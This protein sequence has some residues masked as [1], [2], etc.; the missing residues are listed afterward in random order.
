MPQPINTT[1]NDRAIDPYGAYTRIDPKERSRMHQQFALYTA[2]LVQRAILALG[3]L[4][5]RR[6]LDVGPGYGALMVNLDLQHD[7]V[8]AELRQLDL[9]AELLGHAQRCAQARGV[10]SVNH[11]G[12]IDAAP[13]PDHLL[14]NDLVVC[15]FTATHFRNLPRAMVHM[16]QALLPAGLLVLVDVDYC[17]SLSAGCPALAQTLAEVQGRLHTTDLSAAL[18]RAAMQAG[19]VPAEGMPCGDW[20]Q[21]LAGAEAVQQRGLRFV[22]HFHAEDPAL[23]AWRRI[24]PDAL[25]MLRRMAHI[26]TR[27]S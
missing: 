14:G 7:S 17:A 1:A 26:Y 22:S 11:V 24:G 21:T 20:L 2:P 10:V 6:V 8:P 19:L 5:G 9:N 15:S 16:H 3:G 25:L 13:L 18:P 4:D 23:Q 27:R 12:A